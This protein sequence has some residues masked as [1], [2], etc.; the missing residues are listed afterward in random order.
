[1]PVSLL[2]DHMMFEDVKVSRQLLLFGCVFG[3]SCL[4][5]TEQNWAELVPH[6]VSNSALKG[7]A[8]TFSKGKIASLNPQ[9]L[10]SI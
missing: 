4:P 8:N 5:N 10:G 7:G 6:A 2:W 1:M 3:W 9:K